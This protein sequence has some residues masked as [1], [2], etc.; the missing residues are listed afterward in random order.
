LT[1]FPA[2][3]TTATKRRPAEQGRGHGQTVGSG[4]PHP[5]RRRGQVFRLGAAARP[6]AG[7]AAAGE[8]ARFRPSTGAAVSVWQ[9]RSSSCRARSSSLRACTRLGRSS[10]VWWTCGCSLRPTRAS[11]MAGWANGSMTLLCGRSAGRLPRRC[12]SR[13]SGRRVRFLVSLFEPAAILTIDLR[14][15]RAGVAQAGFFTPDMVLGLGASGRGGAG[16][17]PGR[18]RR[19]G[20]RRGRR[21]GRGS[22]PPVPH[23]AA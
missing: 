5:R 18:F 6:A 11:G 23:P 4:R 9:R 22:A 1:G 13:A 15:R 12:T 20:S 19:R 2:P 17:R 21:A 14:A 8:P 7:P 3:L 16:G 10:M